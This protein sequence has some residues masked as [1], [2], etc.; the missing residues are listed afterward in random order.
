MS[1]SI[2]VG[3]MLLCAI[4]LAQDCGS[5]FQVSSCSGDQNIIGELEYGKWWCCYSITHTG[6]FLFTV[7]TSDE[8]AIQNWKL[9][10]RSGSS[11]PQWKVSFELD[12]AIV[13]GIFCNDM[14]F[15]SSIVCVTNGTLVIK[16]EQFENQN[17]TYNFKFVSS[18]LESSL[19]II[20]GKSDFYD[21]ELHF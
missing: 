17:G 2:W 20:F 3:M 16:R 19:Q 9:C 14:A 6:C 13:F 21:I 18:E 8:L 1:A 10:P 12:S 7:I 4:A 11:I 15:N 5:G